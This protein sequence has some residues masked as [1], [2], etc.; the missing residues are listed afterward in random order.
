MSD[1]QVKPDDQPKKA[2]RPLPLVLEIIP[3]QAGEGLVV[4]MEPGSY[5]EF[6]LRDLCRQAL[7]RT[8]FSIEDRQIL[9]D[10]K[11]QLQGGSSSAGGGTWK[12]PPNPAA[13]WERPR[14]GKLAPGT[15]RCGPL[16]PRRAANF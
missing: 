4:V 1:V 9:E 11:R 12:A 13:R 10:I 8:D 16:S 6:T 2:I 7:E 15:C 3:G 5:E 14:P